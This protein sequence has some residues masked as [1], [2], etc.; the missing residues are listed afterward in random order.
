MYE[1]HGK[2]RKI[3]YMYEKYGTNV[4]KTLKDVLKIWK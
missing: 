1:K 4:I 2:S 3:H